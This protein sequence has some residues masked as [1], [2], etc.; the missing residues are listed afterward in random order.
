MTFDGTCLPCGLWNV[1]CHGRQC[2]YRS[3]FWKGRERGCW[4]VGIWKRGLAVL[5]V[6]VTTDGDEIQNCVP[7]LYEEITFQFSETVQRNQ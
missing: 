5:P 4:Q 1:D 7:L 2:W 6:P 3:F